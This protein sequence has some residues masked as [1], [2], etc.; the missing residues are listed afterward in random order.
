VAGS[1]EGGIALLEPFERKPGETYVLVVSVASVASVAAARPGARVYA[2]HQ[3]LDFPAAETDAVPPP[4]LPPV[5]T[6]HVSSLLPYGASAF[7]PS[8]PATPPAAYA[9]ER[10]AVRPLKPSFLFSL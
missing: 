3:L 9:R 10:A 5:L 2:A 8:P 4:P 6:G 7:L 1:E